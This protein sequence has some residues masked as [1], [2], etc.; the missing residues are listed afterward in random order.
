MFHVKHEGWPHEDLGVALDAEQIARLEAFED[1]IA[2]L[3]VPQG[4][5][6]SKDLPRLRSRHI[7]DCLRGAA[8]VDPQ[9]RSALDMGSGAGLP[10][11]VMAIA[12]PGLAIDLV[13]VRSR[14]AAFLDL[15]ID[16]LG[17]SNTSVHHGR[18]EDRSTVVDL[19]LARAFASVRKSWQ[20]AEPRLSDRGRLL[21]WAGESF[22]ISDVPEG[23]K[24][25]VSQ[26]AALARSGPLVM[27]CRQ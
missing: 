2:E 25:A 21:Y 12:C 10:G 11:I 22:E 27:M 7:L 4:M 6:G 14:R 13:E 5:V 3:A 9:D 8:A 15:A 16:R 26:A 20:V 18:V 1:L 19:C 17:L 23:V 24:T